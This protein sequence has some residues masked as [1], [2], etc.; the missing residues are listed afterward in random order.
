MLRVSV[1]IPAY[2]CEQYLQE[3]VA[4]AVANSWPDKEI[5]ILNDGSTDK[6]GE[7]ASQLAQTYPGLVWA[8]SHPDGLNHGLPQ[9]RNR[10]VQEAT[11]DL[12]AFL[13]ADDRFLPE[14]LAH[15]VHAL[16]AHPDVAFTYGR[17]RYLHMRATGTWFTQG[18]WGSGPNQGIVPGAFERLL[19]ANVV[20]VM[21][22]VCRRQ[23]FLE[24]GGFVGRVEFGDDK[25]VRFPSEEHL[26][27]TMLVYRSSVYYMDELCAEYRRHPES[28]STVRWTHID[29]E[30][31]AS[32][33]EVEYLERVAR[34]VP[35]NDWKTQRSLNTAWQEIGNRI[36][37]RL[38]RALREQDFSQAQRELAALRQV[39]RKARLVTMPWRWYHTRAEAR[40]QSRPLGQDS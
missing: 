32:A 5:L 3:A 40:R 8:L 22:V 1:I 27:W 37:Y 2:N 25:G 12:I 28:R 13:D 14:H 15:A 38:Y 16:S 34:W 18:E 4:S 24:A 39:P 20:P 31:V 9:T 21:T 19:E 33:G 30:R 35:P 36:L 6:T 29:R 17:V 11:G 10:L 7:I 23:R 26:L